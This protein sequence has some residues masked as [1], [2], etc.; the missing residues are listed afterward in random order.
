MAG[1]K[2][3]INGQINNNI[4]TDGLVFYVDPAYKKSYPGSGTASTDL[5]NSVTGTLQSSG[6]FENINGGTFDFDGGTNYIEYNHI[7]ITGNFTVSFWANYTSTDTLNI[8]TQNNSGQATF[9]MY[10]ISDGKIGFWPSSN[11]YYSSSNE[12]KANTATNNG[13][14]N[15]IVLINKGS[16]LEIYINGSLDNSNSNGVPSP[17]NG[18]SNFWVGGAQAG[19]PKFNGSISITKLYNRALSASE[20]LQNYQAQKERFGL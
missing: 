12:I 11:G 18:T 20:I 19:G 14:W 2:S 17:L 15:N 9:G 6:M 4:I 5:V 1:I 16:N 7:D 3:G 13:N 10:Q 8:I